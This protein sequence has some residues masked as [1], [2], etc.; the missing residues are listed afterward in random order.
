LV[1]IIVVKN[2]RFTK[3]CKKEFCNKKNVIREILGA[4]NAVWT[5]IV[6]RNV[7]RIKA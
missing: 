7:V 3:G 6:I 5:N 2:R 1:A 4:T